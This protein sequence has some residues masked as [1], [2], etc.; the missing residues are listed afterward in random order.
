MK[1]VQT[2]NN[3]GGTEREV[4]GNV[5]YQECVFVIIDF[6]NLRNPFDRKLMWIIY[7]VRNWRQIWL[8]VLSKFGAN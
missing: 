8:L 4:E 7:I 3:M 1:I 6:K 5:R 2:T